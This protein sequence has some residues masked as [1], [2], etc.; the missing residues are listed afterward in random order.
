MT[1]KTKLAGQMELAGSHARLDGACKKLLS[2]KIILAWILKS[3]VDEF[4]EYD[5]DEI[6]G[7]Y[8]EG[9]PIVAQSAV[10]QDEGRM[11]GESIRG[12]DTVHKTIAEGTV[13]FDI[14]FR[15]VIP[16]GGE[17]ITLILNVE[18]QNDFYPGYPLVKRGIYYCCRMVSGQHG[19]EFTGSDYEGIKKVYSIWICI[20]PPKDRQNT[21]T[22]YEMTETNIKGEVREPVE[23]YDIMTT[24]MLC[25]G[26]EALEGQEG[27]LK[28]LSVLLSPQLEVLEKKELLEKEFGIPMTRDLE[29]EVT[30]M[31]NYSKGIEERGIQKGIEQGIG[32]GIEQGMLLALSSLVKDGLLTSKEA[33]ARMNLSEEEFM[34]KMRTEGC[35]EAPEQIAHR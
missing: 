24:V 33:A 6:A 19:T 27:A 25:L 23:N 17:R 30:E 12:D 28:L 18:A 20:N 34:E 22:K 9:E 29:E 21:I 3:T 10:H 7:R 26:G 8:I 35:A 11:K 4:K 13:T 31:C 16:R 32:L 14:R 1:C 5:V 2:N 15:A